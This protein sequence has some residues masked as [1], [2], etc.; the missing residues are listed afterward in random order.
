MTTAADLVVGECES[1]QQV[2]VLHIVVVDGEVF[3][4]C[5]RCDLHTDG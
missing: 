3:A 1:C 4:V 5:A 2:R